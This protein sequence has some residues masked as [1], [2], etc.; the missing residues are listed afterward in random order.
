MK[1]QRQILQIRK[2][3]LAALISDSRQAAR[4][5]IDECAQA[6]GVSAEKFQAYET[7]LISP[8]LPQL[9]VLSLYLD[10][11][12][13][14]YWG[15]QTRQR[16]E[17]PEPGKDLVRSL[18]I[19]NRLIAASIK[20]IRTNA[21]MSLAQLAE[22]TGIGEETLTKY[23]QGESDIPLPELELIASG[24]NKPIEDFFDQKGVAG[25]QRSRDELIQLFFQLPD[26]LQQFAAQ[27]VNRPYL[28]LAKKLSDM[29]VQKLRDIAEKLL[30]ITY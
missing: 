9:E 13:A 3:K 16:I 29:D 12:L 17:V 24:Y 20:L 30:E 10:V 2:R 25:R 8:S 7:G 22:A 4:R 5:S 28:E 15:K 26:D 18:G 11:P 21:G 14:H 1:N 19:R 27:P 23:E 6:V